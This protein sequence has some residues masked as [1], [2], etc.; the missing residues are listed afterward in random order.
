MDEWYIV[1]LKE[2]LAARDVA[3]KV[4]PRSMVYVSDLVPTSFAVKCSELVAGAIRE[5]PEVDAIYRARLGSH[6]VRGVK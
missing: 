1:Q 3:M 5:L 2:G 6:Y 4:L